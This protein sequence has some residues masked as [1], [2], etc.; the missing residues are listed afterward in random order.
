MKRRFTAAG[1]AVAALIAASLQ[2]GINP[3]NGQTP[4]PTS[5]PLGSISGRFYVDVDPNNSFGGPDVPLGLPAASLELFSLDVGGP[6]LAATS[7]SSDGTYSFDGLPAGQY[8]V[9]I[10]IPIVACAVPFVPPFDWVGE[11][12]RLFLCGNPQ[13]STPQRDIVLGAGETL[14][15]VDLPQLPTSYEI[16]ARI[17]LNAAPLTAQNSVMV[18]AGGNPCW[19]A[20]VNT[21]PTLAGVTVSHYSA[22]LDPLTDPSCQS[23]NLDITIDS[24][25]VGLAK[26]WE[27]FWKES[28][29]PFGARPLSLQLDV[30]I[31]GFL[32]IS[33]QVA[34]AGTV[35]PENVAEHQGALLADGTRVTA[36]VGNTACG[37]ARTKA[38][39]SA[40]TQAQPNGEFG[41]NLFGLIVPPA[42]VKTGCGTAGAEVTFCIGDFR[43]R[44]PAAGPFSYFQSPESK[45]VQW[46]APALA[47]ITLEPTTEPCLAV[48]ATPGLAP[49]QPPASL[50][51]TGGRPAGAR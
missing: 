9:S 50:P 45:P 46:A 3:A 34:E 21:G 48:A 18:T 19:N 25:A 24:R 12:S 7:S 5:G 51:A 42:G 35:T 44:Q 47:D 27:E 33:G 22:R 16:S 36:F 11:P 28:L 49:E 39:R 32:G 38:L 8:R 6:P 30:A 10:N 40:P 26:P 2:L 14:A 13:F 23:G 31:P 15:N 4:T 20:Q 1:L 37:E 29:F 41:G 43:A 17:W